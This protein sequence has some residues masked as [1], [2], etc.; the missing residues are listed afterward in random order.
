MDTVLVSI[1]INPNLTAGKDTSACN[2]NSVILTANGGSNYKWSNSDTTSSI[3]ISP[4]STTLY[5]VTISD[6]YKCRKIDSIKVSVYPNPKASFDVKYVSQSKYSFTNTSSGATNY[7]WNF[8]DGDTSRTK[9]PQHTYTDN[10]GKHTV[11]LTINNG[12]PDFCSDTISH[13]TFGS[14]ITKIPDVFT[15][16]S[17]HNMN[18]SIQA[19]NLSSI[20]LKI[21]NRW[22]IMIYEKNTVEYVNSSNDG[23]TNI[24]LWN[25]K[26]KNGNEAEAGVYFY[27]LKAKGLDNIVY[28]H[29]G[30][31]TLLR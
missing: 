8:G 20:D 30:T 15:P 24:L 31:I 11:L 4:S 26:T 5:F 6:I 17:D 22:G 18:F 23:N 10:K 27:V 25:A 2:G 28:N 3:S 29:Q 21:F 13:E 12:L 16:N 1:R 14:N 9:N 19:D 7:L